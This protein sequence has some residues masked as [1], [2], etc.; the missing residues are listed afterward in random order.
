MTDL[1]SLR[2][3]KDQDKP[4]IDSYCYGEGMDQ[5]SSL[6]EVTVA[7][8]GDDVPVGFIRLAFAEAP[9]AYVNPIVVVNT[10]RGHGVGRALIEHAFRSHEELRL[11][12]RGTSR[13]FYDALGF[14]ACDWDLIENGVSEDCDG[15]TMREECSPIPMRK[16]IE[17]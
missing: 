17:Y 2:A 12:S 16:R 1:F 9:C 7:V 4:Y 10:W 5:L 11:V 13:A 14:S 8:N 6:D 15:C 3:A